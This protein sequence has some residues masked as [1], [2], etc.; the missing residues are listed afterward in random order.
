MLVRS[1]KTENQ[2]NRLKMEDNS[3]TEN[4]YYN[5]Y[6]V[7][8]FLLFP[9]LMI[10]PLYKLLLTV[11]TFKGYAFIVIMTAILLFLTIRIVR[12]F[13][14][15]VLKKPA[16]VLSKENLFDFQTGLTF[17]WKDIKKFKMGT[18]KITTISVELYDN[19]K[20]IA[21]FRNP[22]KRFIYRISSKIF[23]ETFT[24][25]ISMLEGNNGMILNR[26]ETYLK[27]NG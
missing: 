16:L 21:L 6:L 22:I 8:S 4:F 19:D 15:L 26:L 17:N 3:S 13:I 12:Y 1:I 27:D 9:L 5:F 24:F 11:T 23:N 10:N 7:T 14:R 18:F 20:Y 25:N 2:Y